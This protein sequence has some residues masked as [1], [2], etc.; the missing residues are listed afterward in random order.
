MKLLSFAHKNEASSFLDEFDYTTVPELK[1]LFKTEDHFLL[2]TGEGQI[3]A[4][5]QINKALSLI[6]YK[7]Q[8]ELTEHINMG[9]CGGLRESINLEQIYKV[10][11]IYAEKSFNQMQFQSYHTDNGDIDLVS[12]YDR[13]KSNEHK[14][15]LSAFAHL[16]D[17][18]AWSLARA[19]QEF[20]VKFSCY[21]I[22]SDFAGDD[23]HCFNIQEQAHKFS[24]KL[25]EFYK[26]LDH[27]K[28]PIKSES[29]PSESGLDFSNFH[30]TTSQ[31]NKLDKLLQSACI[32]FSKT[33]EWVLSQ[34][35]MQDI[36]K[37]KPAK[38]RTSALLF[39]LECLLNPVKK[40]IVESMN[41]LIE[42]TPKNFHVN[43]DPEFESTE[44]NIKLSLHSEQQKQELANYLK[45]FPLSKLQNIIN[46]DENAI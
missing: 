25:Y 36:E 22:V 13:V 30:I 12:A 19:S 42:N 2:I 43:Y 40:Q 27:Q 17:R 35:P 18:E 16:V 26:T 39:E 5:G 46:G 34:L 31:K 8:I 14:Q 1:E 9:V 10:R 4:L 44:I 7:Y 45:D 24:D 38:K 20:K 32:A 41:E 37:L 11:S 23:T 6:T 21:K 29:H 15:M 28:T 3:P 33:P